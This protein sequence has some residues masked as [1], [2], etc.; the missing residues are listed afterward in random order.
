V[1]RITWHDCK[2]VLEFLSEFASAPVTW[3]A[4]GSTSRTALPFQPTNQRKYPAATNV[5]DAPNNQEFDVRPR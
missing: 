2:R 3:R 1:S 4:T 5:V